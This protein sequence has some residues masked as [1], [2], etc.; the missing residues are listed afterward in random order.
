MARYPARFRVGDPEVPM[1]GRNEKLGYL[2]WEDLSSRS[3]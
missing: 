2:S 1:I 3:A